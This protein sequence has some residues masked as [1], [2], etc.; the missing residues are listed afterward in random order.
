MARLLTAQPVRFGTEKMPVQGGIV[1]SPKARD[2]VVALLNDGCECK[3]AFDFSRRCMA[4]TL[5]SVETETVD[6]RLC[7]LWRRLEGW[8]RR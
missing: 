3:D 5:I 1:I 6:G 7:R 8:L 2:R 4:E